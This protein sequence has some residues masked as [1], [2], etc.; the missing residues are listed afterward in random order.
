MARTT[1]RNAQGRRY[2]LTVH[3]DEKDE[4][5]LSEMAARNRTT[6]SEIIRRLLRLATE[7]EVVRLAAAS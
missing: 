2:Q 4:A 1:A 3:L 5:T 6:K 7:D